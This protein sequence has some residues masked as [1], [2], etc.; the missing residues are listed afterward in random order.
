MTDNEARGTE[1]WS[2]DKLELRRLSDRF[3]DD[4]SLRV[5]PLYVEF[6]DVEVFETVMALESDVD[7]G[8]TS[9]R[10]NAKRHNIHPEVE[11]ILRSIAE[12]DE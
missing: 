8:Y 9:V 7:G 10:H 4:Y 2:S 12:D 3:A 1:L 5:G 11:G 6:S